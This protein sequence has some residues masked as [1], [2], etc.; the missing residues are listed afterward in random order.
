MMT[1]LS[2]ALALLALGL[3]TALQ[4]PTTPTNPQK[5]RHAP[6]TAI[7]S[8]GGIDRTVTSADQDWSWTG[9]IEGEGDYEQDWGDAEAPE[10]SAPELTIVT[11]REATNQLS[12]CLLYTS[13]SPRDATLSRM[14]SSA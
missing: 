8:D 9:M 2:V 11:S 1:P 13:P 6:P 12:D 7:F 5:L 14:P 3:S 10:G 4:L